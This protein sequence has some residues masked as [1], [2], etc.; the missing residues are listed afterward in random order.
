MKFRCFVSF[1][2]R[3][4]SLLSEFGHKTLTIKD[5]NRI[6]ELVVDVWTLSDWIEQ[7][8]HK[9]NPIKK[10]FAYRLS[11]SIRAWTQERA[12]K[13]EELATFGFP[14]ELVQEHCQKFYR[15]TWDGDETRTCALEWANGVGGQKLED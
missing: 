2:E 9:Y 3:F 1:T 15:P 10:K 14:Y 4:P 8:S 7:R 13:L 12:A 11:S 6:Q 5:I